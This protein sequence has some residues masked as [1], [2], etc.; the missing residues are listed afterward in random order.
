MNLRVEF[1]GGVRVE[2]KGGIRVEF[3]GGE[4]EHL[5][6]AVDVDLVKR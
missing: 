6:S 5:E 1:K 3:K 4:R 2:F